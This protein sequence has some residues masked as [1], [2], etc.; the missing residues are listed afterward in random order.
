[1]GASVPKLLMQLGGRTLIERTVDSLMASAAI[2]RLVLVAPPG[3]EAA[4]RGLRYSLP[5]KIDVVTGGESRAD[6]VRRGL[7]AV[8]GAPGACGES[9]VLVHDGAR[10][11]ITPELVRRAVAAAAECGAVT[12]A[13]PSV[14]SVKRVDAKGLVRESLERSELWCVQTPQVFRL[15]LL[16][17]AHESGDLQATDDASLVERIHPVRVVHGEQLNLKVTTPDDLRLAEALLV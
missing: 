1:M 7:A 11:L 3:Q 12:A 15:D 14:D 10:C 4:F 9:L 8:A 16:L 13:V 17:R 6:S 5:Q 2:E